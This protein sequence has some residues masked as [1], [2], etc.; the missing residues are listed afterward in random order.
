VYLFRIQLKP[1]QKDP[2]PTSLNKK[3]IHAHCTTLTVKITKWL[4]GY[5]SMHR[6]MISD[7]FYLAP[8]YHKVFPEALKK[9]IVLG[10]ILYIKTA[11]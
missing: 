2:A 6:M 7:L 9:V 10:K 5:N 1:G 11:N 8:F 3:S 4:S